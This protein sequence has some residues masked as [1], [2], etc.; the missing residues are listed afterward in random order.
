MANKPNT[1]S[2]EAK[3]E[4]VREAQSRGKWITKR[5]RVPTLLGSPMG[6]PDDEET[7]RRNERRYQR[8]YGRKGRASTM[9]TIGSSLG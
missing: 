6:L 2:K 5:E 4:K 7:K 3:A 8:R 9:L 1:K